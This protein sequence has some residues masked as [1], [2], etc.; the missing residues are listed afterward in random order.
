ML[1]EFVIKT[2]HAYCKYLF[3]DSWGIVQLN[4]YEVTK[5][6]ICSKVRVFL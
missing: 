3:L 5:C 4:E 6:V 1:L 2:I